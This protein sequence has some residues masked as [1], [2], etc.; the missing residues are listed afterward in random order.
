MRPYNFT[1]I[2]NR[3]QNTW[4]ERG[5]FTA[6]VEP[7]RPKYYVLEMFPYPSGKLHMGHVRNYSIGDVVARTRRA[8]GFNVL[9]PMG[10]D[11]FGLPAENAA[12]K[13][14]VHPAEWTYS[15]IRQMRGQLKALGYS[16][17][18]DR[19]IATCHPEY[20]RW[21]QKIFQEMIDRDLAYRKSSFVNWCHTCQTVLANEQVENGTC[22]RCGET[23]V[24]RELVQWFLRI[25]AY[26]QSLLDD[27][28]KLEGG[29]PEK[30]LTMQRNWIGRSEGARVRFPLVRPVGD[31]HEIEVFTTRP[32]TLW[33]VTFMSLAAEHPLALKL[34]AGGGREAEVTAFVQKVRNEDRTR[35]TSDDFEKEGCFT[36]AYVTNPVN[37]RQVP[38][39]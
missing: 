32:D 2:E 3:W 9:Y 4:R 11:A 13:A 14:H 1:E 21:E 34:A 16:Y 26:A 29:W 18:W 7:G 38:V 24:Q 36:G 22:W 15:N 5:V 25:T 23:V 33:G 28:S 6:K 27:L 12:I 37:G 31:V 30:V 10:W 8:M 39:Y 19:E 20:F 17:D 35:R